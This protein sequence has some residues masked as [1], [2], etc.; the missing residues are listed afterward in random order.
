[1]GRRLVGDQVEPFAAAAQAGSISA[2][3]P[4]SAMLTASPFVADSRAQ[5]SAS[6]GRSVRR[7]T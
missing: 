6:A 5:A 3:L 1:M 4:T 7:S 2:A